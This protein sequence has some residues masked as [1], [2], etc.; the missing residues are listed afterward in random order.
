[1]SFVP[2]RQG[3]APPPTQ[4]MEHLADDDR[5][6]PR[7]K[8]EAELREMGIPVTS[9]ADVVIKAH[10]GEGGRGSVFRCDYASIIF[11]YL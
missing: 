9:G 8:I 7:G 4:Q 6:V 5:A 1:M 3:R 11:S 10:L 2:P